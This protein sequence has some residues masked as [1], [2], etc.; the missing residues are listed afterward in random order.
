MVLLPNAGDPTLD[1]MRRQC[2]RIGNS[3]E[4]RDYLGASLIG[5]PCERQIWYAYHHYPAE[6]FK[7]ET[8]WNFEDGHRTEDLIAARLRLVPG[9]ELYTH[10]EEGNQFGFQALGG[11]FRGHTDGVIVGLYQAPKTPHIWENKASGQKK[12]NEFQ[13]IKADVGEKHALRKWNENYFIQAQLYMHYLECDRH[14]L[15]VAL[16]GGREI[17]SCRTEYQ[18]DVAENAINKADRILQHRAPPERLSNRPDYYYCK[19]FCAFKGECHG[20]S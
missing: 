18:P 8:L 4:P 13:A 16:A 7:A 17:D 5:N 9:I 3:K 19:H 12:F 2:E 15:T 20:K 1:E 10:D 6:P 11:K 14:Y